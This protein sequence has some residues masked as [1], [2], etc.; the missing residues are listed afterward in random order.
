MLTAIVDCQE[1]LGPRVQKEHV[2]AKESRERRVNV[3]SK[4]RL[5]VK[6]SKAE[7]DL[8]VNR[9]AMAPP[10][11]RAI[12]VTQALSVKSG[13]TASEVCRA[14]SDLRVSKDVRDHEDLRDNQA[15]RDLLDLL[16]N[17]VWTATLLHQW[18]VSPEVTHP[19]GQEVAPAPG[20]NQ[21]LKKKQKVDLAENEDQLQAWKCKFSIV[22][23][24]SARRCTDWNTVTTQDTSPLK[25]A[26]IFSF[27]TPFT[28]WRTVIMTSIPMP[29][30]L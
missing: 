27:A 18:C 4:G 28:T 25:P 24:N 17:A 14:L 12:R 3:E 10:D 19:K 8:L 7:W 21:A 22:L 13:Q 9:V 26:V 29:D 30:P 20:L 5:A 15:D 23:L 11:L 2:E 1:I 6:A 16:A